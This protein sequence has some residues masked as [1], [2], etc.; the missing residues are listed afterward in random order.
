MSGA[1]IDLELD[2]TV[3]DVIRV[4]R[5]I[6]NSF[7][8]RIFSRPTAACSERSSLLAP[9]TN[10]QMQVERLRA[11][12]WLPAL[13]DRITTRRRS[14]RQQGSP[15]GNLA[16]PI[17]S[18]RIDVHSTPAATKQVYGRPKWLVGDGPASTSA[19]CTRFTAAGTKPMREIISG[20]NL[21]CTS[22]AVR[23]PDTWTPRPNYYPK[24]EFRIACPLPIGRH[25][26][27]AGCRSGK[28]HP[29]RWRSHFAIASFRAT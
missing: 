20:R 6:E 29:I 18:A 27:S 28:Y 13:G 17:F 23:K 10:S 2:T 4:W 5:C 19:A 22:E 14:R 24:S 9:S 11:M 25:Q 15:E 7:S 26:P 8:D 12:H 16:C 21:W 1:S 3:L